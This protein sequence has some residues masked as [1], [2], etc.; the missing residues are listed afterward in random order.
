MTPRRLPLDPE[1]LRLRPQAYVAA[2]PAAPV[3]WTRKALAVALHLACC[4]LFVMTV[5]W[6][7]AS[8]AAQR[9]IAREFKPLRDAWVE[10]LAA[11]WPAE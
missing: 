10:W 3:G 11:H 9:E 4:W 2:R 8:P 6:P 1:I 5:V 7:V